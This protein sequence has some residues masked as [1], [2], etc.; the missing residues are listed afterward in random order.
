MMADIDGKGVVVN[1]TPTT[2]KNTTKKSTNKSTSGKT[3]TVATAPVNNTPYGPET[4]PGFNNTGGTLMVQDGTIIPYNPADY[5]RGSSATWNPQAE[6]GKTNY[7]LDANGQPVVNTLAG[8][9]V[10]QQQYLIWIWS[11]ITWRK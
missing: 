1:P 10:G 11:W 5:G 4:D 7:S 8:T 9:S 2:S 3:S 6:M